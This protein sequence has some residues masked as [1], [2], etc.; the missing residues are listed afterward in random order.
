MAEEKGLFLSDIWFNCAQYNDWVMFGF[1]HFA[2]TK[3]AV[4]AASLSW[5]G[6]K[7]GIATAIPNFDGQIVQ[8]NFDVLDAYLKFLSQE[9][10]I[11]WRIDAVGTLGG[12]LKLLTLEK[13]ASSAAPLKILDFLELELA[14]GTFL[15]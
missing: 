10:P 13:C 1:R 11:N 7:K 6:K 8:L 12:D 3:Y 15:R 9:I 5:D 2:A 14:Y 4:R